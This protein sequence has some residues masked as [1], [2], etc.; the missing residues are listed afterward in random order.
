MTLGRENSSLDGTSYITVANI[1]LDLLD[2][3][4]DV[5]VTSRTRTTHFSV[6]GS[7]GT[8]MGKRLKWG[9]LADL[10]GFV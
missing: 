1:G 3:T 4:L 8:G 9:H 2:P 5:T 6:S 10:H 7:T